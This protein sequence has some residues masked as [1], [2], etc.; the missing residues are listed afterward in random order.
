MPPRVQTEKTTTYVRTEADNLIDKIIESQGNRTF[1][2]ACITDMHYGMNSYTDGIKHASQALKYI[3]SRVK[4]DAFAVLGDYSHKGSLETEY[5]DA[6]QDFM[7]V[8]G[9]FNPLRMTPNLRV[10]GNHD[11]DTAQSPRIYRYIQGYSDNVVWGSQSGGYFY[12]D[13]ENHKVR[14]ICLNTTEQSNTGLDCSYE[15]YQWFINSLD[16]KDKEDNAEWQILILS[17]IPIDW[18][19]TDKPQLFYQIIDAYQKG[20]SWSYESLSCDYANRNSAK[21]IANIHG[22]IHN[23]LIRK[24]AAG[25]PHSTTETVDLYRVSTPNACDTPENSKNEMWDNNPY[26]EDI[27]YPKTQNTAQDT[28]FCVY[29]IDLDTYTL[30][31]FCYGAGYDRELVYHTTDTPDTT[32]YTNV[33]P[34]AESGDSTEV[35]NSVGYKADT[36]YSKSSQAEQ[37]RTGTYLSGYIERPYPATIYLKN[38]NI[39]KDDSNTMVYWF[40]EKGTAK[41]DYNA[42]LLTDTCNAV[43]DD[44]G[45]LVSFECVIDCKHIRIQCSGFDE[46]SIVTVNETIG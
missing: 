44:N 46:T 11:F 10:Q 15:Q 37:E 3:D 43:W 26:G 40:D 12:R 31:A 9:L 42:T 20:T 35:Y 22:H 34:M 6:V 45:M 18:F 32:T 8:N 33:L 36:R 14:V 25:Y 13:F 39:S 1:T 23:L 27:S 24:I 29:C 4:L 21:L 30:K 38:V 41:A 2:F 19:E 7:S 5:E 28:A 16:L 17:H